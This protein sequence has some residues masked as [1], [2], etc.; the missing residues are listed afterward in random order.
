MLFG[1]VLR[2]W[3]WR[4]AC[5]RVGKRKNRS[6]VGCLEKRK[7]VFNCTG[8][9][10]GA[11]CLDGKF[12][13]EVMRVRATALRRLALGTQRVYSTKNSTDLVPCFS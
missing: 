1:A 11:E 9:R 12:E 13:G 6:V 2:S 4:V 3:E 5:W 10:V 8:P 7:N